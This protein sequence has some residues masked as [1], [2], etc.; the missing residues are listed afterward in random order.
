MAFHEGQNTISH[1]TITTCSTGILLQLAEQNTISH[2]IITSNNVAGISLLV[3]QNNTISH[4]LVVQNTQ[5]IILEGESTR[6]TVIYNTVANNTGYGITSMAYTLPTGIEISVEESQLFPT[7]NSVKWNNLL[8]NN[9]EG[10]SQ[11]I[12][13]GSENVF[14]VNYWDDHDNTDRNG[15]G[16]ADTPYPI[17]GLANNQDLSPLSTRASLSVM[18]V[19]TMSPPKIETPSPPWIPGFEGFPMLLAIPFLLWLRRRQ[20][21]S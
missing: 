7:H 4:N 13:E 1:N 11:A 17:D 16:I 19:T 5:G 20:H 21:Q 12:D 10:S 3:S 6:N 18:N 15:D 8:G 14:S 2:N 9:P